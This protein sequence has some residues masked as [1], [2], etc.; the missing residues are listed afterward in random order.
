VLRPEP[1][2]GGDE[3][4][5]TAADQDLSERHCSGSTTTSSLVVGPAP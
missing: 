2:Q 5:E 4:R 1:E 3:Q